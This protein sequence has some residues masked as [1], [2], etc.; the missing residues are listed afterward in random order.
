MD[1][2]L[3]SYKI[4]FPI[5]EDDIQRRLDINEFVAPLI[6]DFATIY[7]INDTF[8]DV[9]DQAH[10]QRHIASLT[11]WM[12]V[13]GIIF[14]TY[15]GLWPHFIEKP[16]PHFV[17]GWLWSMGLAC[18]AFFGYMIWLDRDE[19]FALARRPIRF[20]R[21]LKKIYTIRQRRFFDSESKGDIVWEMPWTK[22][23]VF[24]VSHGED[25]LGKYYHIVCYETDSNG[26]VLRAFAMGRRWEVDELEELLAQWNYWCV[27]MSDGPEKLPAPMLYL[28]ENENFIESF[29]ICMYSFGF[30]IPVFMR[31]ICMPLILLMFICRRLSLATCRQ[32]RWPAEISK[33]SG[34]SQS[35][36][37]EPRGTTPVGWKATIDARFRGDWPANPHARVLNWAGLDAQKN[38]QHWAEK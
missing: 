36:F 21:R 32:P 18:I 38:A 27:Y 33:A 24:C 2:R 5:P 8:M 11:A 16:V 25:G 23:T 15:L 14:G 19:L 28:A 10:L 35:D 3:K 9:T 31:I 12:G 13:A 17:Y 34:I 6:M 22:D 7:R 20:N 26:N 30:A 4:G 29:F 1:E 37:N